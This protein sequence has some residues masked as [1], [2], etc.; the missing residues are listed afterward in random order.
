MLYRLVAD[1]RWEET[2][3]LCRFIKDEKLWGC[4]AA[5]S[6]A[7]RHLDTVEIALAALTEVDKLEFILHIK[8]IPSEEGRNAELALYRRCPDE[9]EQIMLQARPPLIYRAIKM[10]IRLFRWNRALDLAIKYQKHVDTVLGY[11]QRFLAQLMKAEIDN[12]FKQYA[13]QVG[14]VDWDAIN[15]KKEQERE[16]ERARSSTLK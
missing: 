15:A 10:N 9:A 4:L 3:R 5:M 2:V 1:V 8:Q 16:D 13:Q 14:D 11:R 12:R 7:G 6:I